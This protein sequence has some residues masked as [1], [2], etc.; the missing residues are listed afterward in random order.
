M[1]R[2]PALIAGTL[3]AMFGVA[4]SGL[5]AF[6]H[7]QTRE[8]IA[9]NERQALLDRLHELVPED[10]VDNDMVSDTITVSDPGRLGSPATTVYRGRKEGE[11]VAL[12]LNPVVPNGYAGPIKLLV[13]VRRDGT[14]GGVRVISHKETPGLGDKIETDRSDWVFGFDGKSLGDPPAEKWKV[15][16]DGGVFDQFTGATITPRAIVKTV[17]KTLEY[18][19]DHQPELYAPP[20]QSP[21][22]GEK[23]S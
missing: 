11:P 13:A 12:V 17:E 14:L 23:E 9:A 3:L 8:R 16:K 22:K 15:K 21:A 5:V 18:V 1:S 6:T 20:S 19:H 2:H 7:D 10:A 4:G